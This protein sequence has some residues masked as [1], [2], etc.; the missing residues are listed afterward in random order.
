MTSE[1]DVAGDLP[2]RIILAVDVPRTG[3]DCLSAARAI[4]QN[5]RNVHASRRQRDQLRDTAK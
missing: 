5:F 4:H 3:P 1:F 2:R